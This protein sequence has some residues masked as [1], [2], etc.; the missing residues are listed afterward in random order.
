MNFEIPEGLTDMLQDFTVAVLRHKP[1]DL[2]EFAAE[3][4][5][6]LHEKSGGRSSGGR[7]GVSFGAE[8]MDE[9]D[10]DEPLPGKLFLH[11]HG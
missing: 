2:H 8:P 3:Y 9:N 1:S 5:T 4:F 6:N 7:K 11:Q 10:D